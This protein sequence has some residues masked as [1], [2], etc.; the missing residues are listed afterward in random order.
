MQKRRAELENEVGPFLPVRPPGTVDVIDEPDRHSQQGGA[1]GARWIAAFYESTNPH[2]LDSIGLVRAGTSLQ[3]I[4]LDLMVAT[5]HCLSGVGLERGFVS[6]RS[7]ADAFLTWWPEATGSRTVWESRSARY[8]DAIVQRIQAL[9][10][11]LDAGRRLPR[12][13]ERWL[14]TAEPFFAR[15]GRSLAR[16]EFTVDPPWAA[17]ARAGDET[18]DLRSSPFHSRASTV[19][20]RVDK[21]WFAQYR[22]A[23]NYLY[24][25]LTRIGLAPYDRFLLCHLVAD[26]CENLYATAAHE[27]LFP[28]EG[29]G[30]RVPDEIESRRSRSS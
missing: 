2:A 12:H 30:V 16:G 3:S 17:A 13:V 18:P 14:D 7:H 5:A 25:H 11:R 22:L 26:A 10:E 28:Q 27:V 4:A 23:L 19:Q 1:E 24:L 29:E 21:V 20:G 8:G 6:F 9:V 15:A